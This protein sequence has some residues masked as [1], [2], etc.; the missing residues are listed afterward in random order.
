[1]GPPLS[2][3]TPRNNNR[4][5]QSI[6]GASVYP[7]GAPLPPPLRPKNPLL[8]KD[9]VGRGKAS[10]YDLPDEGFT[11]GCPDNLDAEGAREVSM[12]WVTHNASER[13]EANKPD[14]VWFNKKSVSSKVVTAR[15]LALYRKEHDSL[16]PSGLRSARE[17][18]EAFPLPSDIVPSFCYG[19][20]VRPST[21]IRQ[22]IS[23]QFGEQSE[24]ELYDFYTEWRESQN[25]VNAQVRKI[26][27][28]RACRGHAAAAKKM[29]LA[30]D[31]A[32]EPFKI[33]KFKKVP[34][35]I[36]DGLYTGEHLMSGSPPGISARPPPRSASAMDGRS[37]ALAPPRGSGTRSATPRLGSAM[38]EAVG[39]GK[40]EAELAEADEDSV[41][42][43]LMQSEQRGGP[44][45]AWA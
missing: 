12:Q 37:P 30:K 16:T 22:I 35:K 9:D 34:P 15:D 4:N 41:L 39:V 18:R 43:I 25:A 2:A 24:R 7:G 36:Y 21:P 1:M 14:F 11:Y 31:E 40:T 44:A 8:V 33:G 10:C 29:M 32:K 6:G 23:N 17:K 5:L 42:G 13:P 20:K 38:R 45:T 27:R 19:K 3:R 26:S 28:T